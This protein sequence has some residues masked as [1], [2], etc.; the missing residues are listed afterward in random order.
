MNYS[1]IILCGRRCSGKTTLFWDLQKSLNW[2]IFSI[3]LYLRDYLH[4]NNL[5]S[6]DDIDKLNETISRDIDLR[7]QK[8]LAT[9]EHIIFDARVYGHINEPIPGALKVLLY[10]SEKVRIGR[11]A[12]RE[13]TSEEIQKTRLIRKEDAWI[14]KMRRMYPYD[15]FDPKYYDLTID[16][17]ELS[18]EDVLQRTLMVLG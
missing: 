1:K 14:E 11:A 7:M 10:A 8:L 3:S 16:T 15:F 2:P 17:S 6:L 9:I 13:G 5:K 12:Y 4:R 18:P